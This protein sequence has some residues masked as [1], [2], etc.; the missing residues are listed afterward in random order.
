MRGTELDEKAAR[1]LVRRSDVVVLHAYGL[2]VAVVEGDEK[3]ALLHRVDDYLRGEAPEHSVFELAD[4][5]DPDRNVMLA[6]QES[7]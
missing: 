2:N 3:A 4:F 6:V 1:R 5:R 7:C